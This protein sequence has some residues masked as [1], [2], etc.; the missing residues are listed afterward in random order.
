MPVLGLDH[1]NVRTADL[2]GTIRFFRE[3]LQMDVRTVPGS[4][5]QENG[6]WVY[7]SNDLAVVHLGAVK[8]VYPTDGSLPFEPAS[9]GGAVHHVALSCADFDGLRARLATHSL[10]F[11]ENDVPKLNLRQIF[12]SEPNGV[13]LEL[14]FRDA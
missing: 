12:V 4:Q 3:V 13:L 11:W 7:D 5:T 8:A 6:A 2:P 14:N 1:V 9:G 10:E